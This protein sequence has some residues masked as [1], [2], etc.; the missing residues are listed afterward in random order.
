MLFS[1]D[2]I[3]ANVD[4]VI[5]VAVP[6]AVVPLADAEADAAWANFDIE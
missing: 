1:M 5:V 4:A 2:D 3:A 6:S